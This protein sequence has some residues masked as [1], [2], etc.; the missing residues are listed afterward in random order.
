MAIS[1][2]RYPNQVFVIDLPFRFWLLTNGTDGFGFES[3]HSKW[4][5]KLFWDRV[6]FGVIQRRC[7]NRAHPDS[8]ATQQEDRQLLR[9]NFDYCSCVDSFG[10]TNVIWILLIIVIDIVSIITI[11]ITINSHINFIF[12][13]KFEKDPSKWIGVQQNCQGR[14]ISS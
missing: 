9:L 12:H 14:L 13:I 10:Y 1:E 5:R 3:L 4:E 6:I 7:T 2:D 8:E 11:M